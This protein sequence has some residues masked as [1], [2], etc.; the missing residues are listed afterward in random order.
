MLIFHLQIIVSSLISAASLVICSCAI[1]ATPH[2]PQKPSRAI[3]VALKFTDG[4]GLSQL[5]VGLGL[6]LAALASSDRL[7][8]ERDV[9]FRLA[10]AL[11]KLHCNSVMIPMIAQMRAEDMSW[12]TGTL[13]TLLW[14]LGNIIP[15]CFE[16]FKVPSFIP[17]VVGA[18]L[19]VAVTNRP[20]MRSSIKLLEI[21]LNFLVLFIVGC[22]MMSPI[23]TAFEVLWLKYGPHGECDLNSG[24]DNQWS[25]GQIL[26]VLLLVL[27]LLGALE[28][29]IG[30]QHL[31]A[32]RFLW[33]LLTFE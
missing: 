14:S 23:N 9:H 24:Q 28:V 12:L 10:A 20:L 17:V 22:G 1:I 29:W 19:V 21:P 4:L 31:P 6:Y 25:L 30:M 18:T 15:A 3:K 27:P 7:D 26:A 32:S 2:T 8:F 11:T 13:R 16:P 5:V 33:T